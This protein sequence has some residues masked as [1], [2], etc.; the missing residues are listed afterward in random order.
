LPLDDY[1]K[2]DSRWPE[3]LRKFAAEAWRRAT[4]GEIND[5]VINSSAVAH[6]ELMARRV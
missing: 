4:N 6:A 3:S 2:E 1:E 5:E